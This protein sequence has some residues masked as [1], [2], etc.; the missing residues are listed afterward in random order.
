[1][2][3]FLLSGS[4]G[5]AWNFSTLSAPSLCCDT[6]DQDII[7]ITDEMAYV[8]YCVDEDVDTMCFGCCDSL[9]ELFLR[10]PSSCNGAFLFELPKVPLECEGSV[11]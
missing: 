6:D 10:A 4:T 1:M 3:L 11:R 7:W 9:Y 2:V 8:E 5:T